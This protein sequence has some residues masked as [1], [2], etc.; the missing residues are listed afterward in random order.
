MSVSFLNAA[1]IYDPRLFSS[2]VRS[3][4]GITLRIC[5]RYPPSFA[6]RWGEKKSRAI[7]RL[8]AALEIVFSFCVRICT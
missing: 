1:V 3:G 2:L 8:V 5:P 4:I 6:M 7:I